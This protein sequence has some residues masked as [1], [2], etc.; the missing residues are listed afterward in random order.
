M[1]K[2]LIVDDDKDI[3]DLISLVL[4]KE[5]IDST[6]VNDSTKVPEIIEKDYFDLILLDIMMPELS[7]IEVCTKIRDKVNC[8][9]IFL[10]AKTELID[11][12]LGYEIGGDDYITKPFNNS[13]LVLKIKS[14]LRL[15]KRV[16]NLNNNNIIKIGEILINKETFEVYKEDEKIELSTREFELLKYLMENAGIVL[17]KEQIFESV[18]GSNYGDIGTVAVNIKSLRDKLKDKNKY[19]ITIWGYGYKFVRNVENEK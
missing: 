10:S 16:N 18:W 9:I 3:S 4:K 17:S 5:G 13:E 2:V 1:S 19:I 15:N 7:G 14:H 12:M 8:P 11:K 6:I